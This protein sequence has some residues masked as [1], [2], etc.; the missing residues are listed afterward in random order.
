MLMLVFGLIV[1]ALVIFGLLW[2]RGGT[3]R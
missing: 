1:V 3:A 2:R